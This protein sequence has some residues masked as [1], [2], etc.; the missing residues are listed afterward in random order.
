MYRYTLFIQTNLYVFFFDNKIKMFI[1]LRLLCVNVYTKYE[2][3]IG[4]VNFTIS[5]LTKQKEKTIQRDRQAD[6]QS[7]KK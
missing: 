1:Y 6:R 4:F 7:D 5:K 2:T 3:Y